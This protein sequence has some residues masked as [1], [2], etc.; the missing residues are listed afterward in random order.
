MCDRPDSTKVEATGPMLFTHFGISGPA[1]F[2]LSSHLAFDAIGA[3]HPTQVRISVD[4]S[5]DFQAWDAELR[6]SLEGEPS[7]LV[8]NILARHLPARFADSIMDSL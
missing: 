6:V 5:K 8:K 2:S 4:A 1:V 3:E 7:R